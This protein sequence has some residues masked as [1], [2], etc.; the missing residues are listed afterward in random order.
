MLKQSPKMNNPRLS[1]SRDWLL[2]LICLFSLTGLLLVTYYRSS[3][4][5][6]DINVNLWAVSIQSSAFTVIAKG[7]SFAFDTVTLIV[8][9][10]VIS[11]YLFYKNY[12]AES[13]LL[14][15]AMAGDALLVGV[16]KDIVMSPRPLNAIAH[17]TGYSFP[18]GHSAVVIVF[19]GLLVFFAWQHWNNVRVKVSLGV[20]V[21][22]LTLLVGF[23][24]LYL[25]VHWFSDVLGGYLTGIFLLASSILVFYVLRDSGKFQS[26]LRS[27]PW[28]IF[29]L[30]LIVIGFI[31]AASLL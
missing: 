11:G 29:I 24:R 6:I 23:D 7:I 13:L 14:L 3:F 10:V 16:I 19:L 28:V 8:V 18:S 30:A 2:L 17:E 15:G 25:N 21:T 26:K 12:R 4:S 27:I 9:S 1:L 5:V 20:T 22:G 31:I